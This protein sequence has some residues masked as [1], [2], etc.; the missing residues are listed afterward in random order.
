MS[1]DGV[2][3]VS[4]RE[5]YDRW[6]AIYDAEANPLVA[7]EAPLVAALLG[8]VRGLKVADVGC[9]TGRHALRL[10][11]E[12]ADVVG[13]DFAEGMIARARAKPGG[14]RVRFIRHDLSQR[15][16]LTDGAVDRVV[17]GLVLDHIA[18]LRGL[19]A[20]MGRI[21]RADGCIVVSVMH[22]AMMLRGVQARFTDPLTGMETRPA[23]VANQVSDYVR[24][25]LAAGLRIVHI[26][27]HMVDEVLAARSERAAKYLGWPILLLMSLRSDEEVMSAER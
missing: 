17:C 8:G 9:G 18:D 7:V 12:G 13:L 27:E 4:T 5:G 11:A 22:P 24:A 19:F 3:H 14:D 2:E 15:L 25:A 21:C 6:A 16:P 23:S 1:G 10:A 20:E 26:S